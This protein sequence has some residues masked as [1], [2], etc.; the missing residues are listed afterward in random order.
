MQLCR[1]WSC[2]NRHYLKL[3]RFLSYGHNK[4]DSFVTQRDK[5]TLADL[6]ETVFIIEQ[7]TQYCLAAP[8][9][10]RLLNDTMLDSVG[11]EDAFGI[12]HEKFF[13]LAGISNITEANAHWETKLRLLDYGHRSIMSCEDL[14]V[15]C[16]WAQKFIPCKDVF[17]HVRT[18]YGM[19]CE[20]NM[21]P[22]TILRNVL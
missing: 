18:E 5:I 11:K 17:R 13:A 16:L 10:R 20:F 1:F 8:S 7:T 12:V 21:M 14:I 4:M 15:R 3:F 22:H 2:S 6:Q 19:C 9:F